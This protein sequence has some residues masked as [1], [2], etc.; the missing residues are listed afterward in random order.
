MLKNLILKLVIRVH[1]GR[2]MWL[3]DVLNGDQQIN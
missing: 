2:V 1:V 3:A